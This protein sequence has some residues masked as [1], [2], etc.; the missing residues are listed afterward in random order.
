MLPR[1]DIDKTFISRG[2]T[3]IEAGLR[4]MYNNFASGQHMKFDPD[5]DTMAAF[6]GQGLSLARK[7]SESRT[8]YFKDGDAWYDYNDKFGSAR[9]ADAVLGGLERSARSAGLM[10]IFGTNP[11]ATIKRMLDEIENNLKSDPKASSKF[12]DSRRGIMDLMAHVDGTANMP[13]H[14]MAARISAG[15]RS[16]QSMSKL[17]GAVISSI[18]D[19]PVYAAE[20]RF[21]GRSMFSG[22]ADAINGLLQGRGSQ[23]QQEIMNSLGVFFDSM[24]NGV[25]RRFDGEQNIGGTMTKLQNQFFKWNGLTWWT[26]TLRKSAALSLSAN[27]AFHK[28]TRFVDLRPD[29]QNLF[30]LY[31]IDEGKWDLIRMASTK[32]ADGRIYM[33]PEGIASL[34]REALENYIVSVGRQ[35]NDASVANLIQDIQGSM[36]SMFIDRAEHAVIEPDARTK[37]FLLRGTNPGTVWGEIARFFAQF[38][39]FP[40]AI[41]QKT[42]GR[43]IYGRGYDNLGDYLKNG[44][45]DML[46]MANMILWM[47]LFGYG[48]MAVKDM[49]KG[50]SPRDPLSPSTWAAAM[51]QG[52]AFGIYGDFLFG[53]MKNRHG[54]GFFATVTGPTFGT[55]EDLFDLWGRLKSGEDAAAQTFRLVIANT[56]FMNLFY[57]RMALDYLIL[58]RVQEW[59]NPGYLRR[60]ER[61]IERENDQTFLIKPSEVIR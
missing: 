51:L 49:I 41:L 33:T 34:T 26:E 8:L 4:E 59:L 32:E 50:R 1:I 52:G 11:E 56:P 44:K 28:D 23:E 14:Q 55:M 18:T 9:F 46:G 48:A 38:K 39:S 47:S 60:M 53:E 25:L 57:T 7:A 13:A 61:R 40:V 17:G 35:V 21:Q 20:Q 6:R 42:I 12:R 29:L 37:A 27:L 19:I 5:E 22:M 54:G 16:W 15:V 3:D 10:K 45:G 24:R 36:R 2:V 30:R 58:Y 43:E 31:N